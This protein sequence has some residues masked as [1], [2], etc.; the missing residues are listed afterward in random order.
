MAI[1]IGQGHKTL[2]G[3][4][5]HLD[6]IIE[7]SSTKRRETPKESETLTMPS[8]GSEWSGIGQI[9]EESSTE[10]KETP[11]ESTTLTMPDGVKVPADNVQVLFPATEAD[12]EVVDEVFE[13]FDNPN[14]S[15]SL[16][17]EA[18][19]APES[20]RPRLEEKENIP[21]AKGENS[22]EEKSVHGPYS[23]TSSNS[24]LTITSSQIQVSNQPLVPMQ[25]VSP[26]VSNQPLMPLQ[27]MAPNTAVSTT[28]GGIPQDVLALVRNQ[29]ALDA[30]RGLT[31]ANLLNT[32][33]GAYLNK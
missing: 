2:E 20:K 33:L 12:L 26:Q 16:R 27:P 14:P 22:L 32:I 1:S 15:P 13:D 23:G 10:R 9:I 25:L 8:G 6:Q 17:S 5:V 31:S 21:P 19:V 3:D 7:E 29:Q 18:H 11:K 30:Q 24:G 28:S 4:A